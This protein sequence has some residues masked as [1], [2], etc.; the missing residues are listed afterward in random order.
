MSHI[1]FILRTISGE[2]E[3]RHKFTH[4]KQCYNW[5][6]Q[7]LYTLSFHYVLLHAFKI[8]S[9][10]PAEEAGFCPVISFPS[11]TTLTCS[12]FVLVKTARSLGTRDAPQ[13]PHP[14]SCTIHRVRQSGP[15]AGK[16]RSVNYQSN[17]DKSYAVGNTYLDAVEHDFFCVGET[18]RGFT[19]ED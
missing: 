8:A 9:P 13:T 11:T 19:R 18:R 4:I 3:A 16:G 5:P 6:F 14:P 2:G 10:R 17:L 12:S 15:P 1:L 7:D